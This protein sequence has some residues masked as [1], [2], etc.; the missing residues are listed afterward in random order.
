[1]MRLT[2]IESIANKVLSDYNI[3]SAPY[4]HIKQ[5]C[6]KE[7]IIIKRAY[8]RENMDGAF[9]IIEG[10]KHIF[11]NP[12]K[13]DGR[14][15][16][17]KAHELGHYFLG[18][19]LKNG[20]IMCS[21]KGISES[22]NNTVLEIEREANRFATCYL[23]PREMIIKEFYKIAEVIRIDLTRPLYVDNQECNMRYWGPVSRHFI[24]R[25]G[26]S[27]EALGYRL[28]ELGLIRYNIRFGGDTK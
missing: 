7:R 4:S 25:F 10:V 27:K 2:E 28:D 1:M 21:N 24:N 18:H 6:D 14:K 8:F 5:I 19:Q 9:A 22:E 11:Y 23:M 20:T 26:V 13:P 16:F 17:T 12:N 15:V 3:Q